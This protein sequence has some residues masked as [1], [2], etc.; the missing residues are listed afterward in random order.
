MKHKHKLIDYLKDPKKSN[1][2]L[3]A[4]LKIWGEEFEVEAHYSDLMAHKKAKQKYI[5]MRWNEDESITLKQDKKEDSI[6][7]KQD[8]KS[9]CVG[10]SYDDEEDG[11]YY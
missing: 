6:S 5:L 11:V 2:D 8:R 9:K 3:L 4:K 7:L 1:K 10:G